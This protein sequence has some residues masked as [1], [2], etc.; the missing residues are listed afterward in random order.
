MIGPSTEE[1]SFV[2]AAPLVA[3]VETLYGSTANCSAAGLDVFEADSFVAELLH[4]ANRRLTPKAA[5]N[6]VK[7]NF[8][9]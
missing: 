3:V 1:F 5:A 6:L 2:S 9:I 7:D 4:A 8:F